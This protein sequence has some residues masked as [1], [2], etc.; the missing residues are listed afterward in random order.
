ME[1]FIH[2]ESQ[3]LPALVKTAFIHLQFETIH[4]YLDGN[5]RI[6]R[7]LIAALLE[8]WGLLPEP[9]MYLSGYLKQHQS[10]YYRRLSNVRTEGDWEAWVAFFWTVWQCQPL[11]L[12]A[13][14]WRLPVCW[15]PTCQCERRTSQRIQCLALKLSPAIWVPLNSITA[16]TVT[17]QTFSKE[18]QK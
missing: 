1:R 4:P 6:G 17:I 9:L 10:E 11:R 15:L 16:L 14:L 5:G 13:A 2:D 7:L 18:K 3:T 12:S 8:H